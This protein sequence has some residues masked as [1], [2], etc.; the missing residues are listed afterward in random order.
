MQNMENIYF[1][2]DQLREQQK[3]LVKDTYKAIKER[4]NIIAH[5]PTGLGKTDAVLSP[6][7]TQALETG[8]NIFFATPKISQHE[9]ALKT[10]KDINEKYGLE[11]KAVELVGKKHLCPDKALKDAPS[12]EFYE[13]CKK[14]KKEEKCPFYS[15]AVGYSPR[16]KKKAK[17]RIN[18]F[19]EWYGTGKTNEQ[20]INHVE[21]MKK[22]LCGYEAVI[23]AG[24]KAQVVICDYYHVL[25]PFISETLMQKMGKSLEDS[26][27]I[28]DEAHNAPDRI[29]NSLSR[30]IGSYSFKKAKKE[31][32]V[33]NRNELKNTLNRIKR[34]I[35][36]EGKELEKN[37]EK[38][39]TKNNLPIPEKE[40]RIQ[41]EEAGINYMKKTNKN[42]SSCL[43]IKKFY[44]KWLEEDQQESYIRIM[45]KWKSG[46]GI[47]IQ[48]KCLDPSLYTEK[49]VN[50]TRS[51]VMMSGTM[52]PQRMYRD[53]IGIDKEQTELK[54]YTSPFPE[55]NQL[56][57]IVPGVTTKYS[58]RN[59]EQYKEIAEKTTEITQ[60]TPGNTAVFFPSYKVMYNVQE[61]L[62]NNIKKPIITQEKG[63]T[64]KER[65]QAL[66][67]FK[68]HS[69]TEEGALL[70]AVSG[71]SYGEG[72]D[73]P[74]Q[75]LMGV[76]IV[77][78][79][80][81]EPDLE[82][83]ALID[84]YDHKYGKG[85]E[86][87]YIFPAMTKAIQ[88][89]GRCIR[90][91]EDKGVIAYL[92]NRYTWKNYSRCFTEKRNMEVTREPGETVKQF[93][94]NNY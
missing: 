34:K 17:N 33:L 21:Q 92:D 28:I 29:R 9:I 61:H 43:A 76:I 90:N 38:L 41:L 42:Q 82:T 70:T 74:G 51:T 1:R 89:A 22:P 93:W 58:E 26:I 57:I 15:Y 67:R 37:G 13:L 64:P 73:L 78:I 19:M 75:E 36:K 81:K 68:N 48:Y 50:K 80:L 46:K 10:I 5:A 8:K 79:P 84:Y 30:Q 72:I 85:W 20:V 11:I 87:G 88:A 31:A 47:T 27:L 60:N 55:Q 71:G 91:E 7:I 45:K 56:K 49:I 25:N 77:G 65:N 14:Q 63:Y 44:D 83:K 32:D 6:A 40:K 35:E 53:L 59:K 66:R 52:K 54:E 18:D 16:E 3:Q 24:K 2:H 62:K 94:Y 69:D 39:I 86:Y 4:K 12:H 23:E